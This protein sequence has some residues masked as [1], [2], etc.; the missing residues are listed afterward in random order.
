M[1]P[2]GLEL[3]R[4]LRTLLLND[5]LAATTTPHLQTQVRL[6]IGMLDAA[7]KELDDAPAAYTEERARMTA[8]AAEA[9][10]LVRRTAADHPLLSDLEALAAS[11]ASPPAGRMT[12][13][14]EES[15]RLLDVLDRLCAF[16]DEYH[17]TNGEGSEVAVLGR[18]VDDELRALVA[19]RA[20]WSGGAVA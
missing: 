4:G 15:A 2:T 14:A 12:A 17:T 3:L 5:V 19:R 6:A 7:V 9:L 16:C 13:M 18:R 11:P 20:K 10:P 8:L 1:R